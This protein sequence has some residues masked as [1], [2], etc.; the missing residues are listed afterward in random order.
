MDPKSEANRPL[1]KLQEM[2]DK[3]LKKQINNKR[4]QRKYYFKIE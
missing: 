2:S 3:V 4:Y 1:R